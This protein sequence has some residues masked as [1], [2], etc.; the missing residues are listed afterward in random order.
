MSLSTL[1]VLGA[2]F[3]GSGIAESA[4]TAGLHVIV[5][6]PD[7]EPLVRS[8]S[9][10]EAAM[11]RARARGRVDDEQAAVILGRIAHT[12]DVGDLVDAGAVVEAIVEELDVKRRLFATLD[13]L[14]P[15]ALFLASNTSSIPIAELA[16]ATSAPTASLACTSSRPCR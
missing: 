11:D 10:L 8:R 14:L 6:E 16:G 3:M 13:E 9:G 2:G 15:S 4:A 7:A 5:Y 12:T 1:G